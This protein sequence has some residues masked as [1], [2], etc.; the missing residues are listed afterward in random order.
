MTS[1]HQERSKRKRMEKR[2][3]SPS[4]SDRYVL[5]YHDGN[6]Q[7]GIVKNSDV[8][9]EKD[10]EVQLKDGDIATFLLAGKHTF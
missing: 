4:E 5:I 9:V 1:I 10:G 8:N 6:G 3:F 2:I 7:Y